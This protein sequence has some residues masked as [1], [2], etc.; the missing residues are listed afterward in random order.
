MTNPLQL[1]PR[2]TTIGSTTAPTSIESNAASQRELHS[3]PTLEDLPSLDG[4]RVL[5][6][7]DLN[8]PLRSNKAGTVEVADDFRLRSSVPTLQWLL[9]RGARV[10]VCS[11]LGRPEG[12][13]D[14]RYVMAPVC[15][16]FYLVEQ[17]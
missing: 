10:T 14:S 17:D 3:L 2:S 15:R 1:Q 12:K 6:R 13:F 16:R 11:H 8:V 9:E 5:V 7:C 4:R